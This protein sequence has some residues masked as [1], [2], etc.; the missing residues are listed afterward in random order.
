MEEILLNTERRAITGKKVQLLRHQGYVP[1]VVYGHHTKPIALKVEERALGQVLRQAG[2]NRLI[3]LKVKGIKDLKHVLVR[4]L[5]RDVITHASLHVDFYEVVMT[6]KVEAEVPIVLI[7]EPL[8]VTQGEGILL[9][10][11]DT[12]RISC[13]PGDLPAQVEVSLADLSA[14]DQAIIVRD[15]QLDDAIEVLSEPDE[16][17]AKVLPLEAE[18]VEIEIPVAEVPEEEVEAEEEEVPEAEA[19]EEARSEQ[20]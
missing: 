6:E 3:A 14:I 1:A 17:I 10:G 13:L 19:E 8:P 11:A 7:G 4:E 20:D 15:L 12:L 5:Q 9:R 2:S 16:L 18:L